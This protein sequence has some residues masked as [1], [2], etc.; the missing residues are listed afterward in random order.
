MA[1][2]FKSKLAWAAAFVAALV[3]LYA[4]VGFKV[5]PGL[6]RDQAIKYVRQNYGREL[7]IGEVRIDPFKLQAEIRDLA[8]PD[9]D[10]SP[11]LGF[12]RLFV[13]FE[14]AS[15]WQRTLIFKDV[16]VEVP[17][18]RAVIR[19]GGAMNFADLAPKKSAP[20]EDSEDSALP[21]VWL[22]SV[23]VK[24]GRADFADLARTRPFKRKF[25]AR[26]V[27]PEGFPH[28]SG[29]RRVPALGQQRS[30]R[31]LRLEG[32]LRTRTEGVVARRTGDRRT[33]GTG[34]GG[35][36]RRRTAVRPYF[37]R[38]EPRRHLRAR[39]RQGVRRQAQAAED[40]TDRTGPAGARRER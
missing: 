7:R 1:R 25:L 5:A 10:G 30:R 12:R 15:L 22:Q 40:R 33:A 13:D 16:I 8:I 20:P 27:F 38:R 37:R 11:M 31:D 34:R 2:I 6:V 18:V 3:G 26:Y 23:A 21:D 19:R 35:I 32:S 28:D 14:L 17:E 24:D 36:P 29:G 4:L 9:A 39:A